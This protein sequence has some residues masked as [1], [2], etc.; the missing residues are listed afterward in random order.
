MDEVPS[1]TPGVVTAESKDATPPAETLCFALPDTQGNAE[2]GASMLND[3]A[4][5]H[6][7]LVPSDSVN[8][9]LRKLQEPAALVEATPCETATPA[10][11]ISQDPVRVEALSPKAVA[12]AKRK[13]Q[14][15]ITVAESPRKWKKRKS[16]ATKPGR[17]TSVPPP[18]AAKAVPGRL[19]RPR[20]GPR[21][22]TAELYSAV[23]NSNQDVWELN[24]SPERVVE[25]SVAEPVPSMKAKS[26]NTAGRPRG[27]PKTNGTFPVKRRVADDKPPAES[28]ELTKIKIKRSGGE[29]QAKSSGQTPSFPPQSGTTSTPRDTIQSNSK[30]KRKSSKKAS[31]KC[32]ID[33]A[34]D[35]GD[36]PR[37][38]VVL[39]DEATSS[40]NEDD[41]RNEIE[42]SNTGMSSPT[43]EE[44]EGDE[45]DDVNVL[46]EQSA[47]KKALEGALYVKRTHWRSDS[48]PRSLTKS[49]QNLYNDIEKSKELYTQIYLF[50]GPKGNEW[51][52]LNEQLRD[53][54][55]GIEQII[56]SLSDNDVATKRSGTITDIYSCAV[57]AL[58][59]LLRSSL[60][61]RTRQEQEPY[62][63]EALKEIIRVHDIIILLCKKARLWKT[64]PPS[65]LNI[66]K[67]TT[68]KIHPYLETT[69]RAFVEEHKKQKIK[70]KEK[71]NAADWRDRHPNGVEQYGERSVASIRDS[72]AQDAQ[73]TQAIIEE[74]ERVAKSRRT[75]LQIR[76]DEQNAALQRQLAQ[77]PPTTK[78]AW[79]REEEMELLF[80]LMEGYSRT[81]PR[82]L[83]KFWL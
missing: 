21:R 75:V 2:D 73:R 31:Q 66:V 61:C 9:D 25:Q 53:S 11:R 47:W 62:D 6:I 83:S 5:D 76:L 10:R 45:V 50:Q 64:R 51:V 13:F 34:H 19:G 4:F 37:D 17:R 49:G 15:R 54:L 32:A 24:P 27:R 57:P 52:K 48:R 67:P 16:E 46:G 40:E 38:V 44:D 55:G 36:E 12:P 20:K 29:F 58:V 69:R 30:A 60:Q 70:E 14:E 63:Y 3:L 81:I 35:A 1:S 23:R 43:Y 82:T 77:N 56:R 42:R 26:V 41:G 71:H 33:D 74:R 8:P 80:Q 59:F 79:T 7:Q 68:Q 22:H 28:G 78:S 72:E 39:D 18:K 65:V